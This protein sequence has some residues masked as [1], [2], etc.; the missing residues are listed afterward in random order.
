MTGLT[1]E[2]YNLLVSP[3]VFN[4]SHMDQAVF[5]FMRYEDASPSYTASRVNAGLPLRPV[6]HGCGPGGLGPRQAPAPTV[7]GTAQVGSPPEGN[8]YRSMR[9]LRA[10]MKFMDPC[11]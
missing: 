6:R 3:S 7:P 10:R 11:M 9:S 4:S 5:A 1:V 2:D 8:S